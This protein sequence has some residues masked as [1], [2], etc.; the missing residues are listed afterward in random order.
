[1]LTFR[2]RIDR[3][4]QRL[5]HTEIPLVTKVVI[6]SQPLPLRT[7]SRVTNFLSDGWIYLPLVVLLLLERRWRLLAVT[8]LA[9]ALCFALY[10]LAK[11]SL[12]RVRPCH[13]SGVVAVQPRCLDRYSFPSGHCMT[14]T[15]FSVLLGW[16]H[17]AAIPFLL[18]AVVLLCWARMADAYHY[19]SDLIGGIGLGL[20]VSV[21]VARILL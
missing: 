20:A 15:L 1:M 12:A 10:F 16:H 21:P 3:M 2:A 17:P 4:I 19:P 6:L 14:L 11:F 18:C 13:L 8:A 9:A 5:D 7:L